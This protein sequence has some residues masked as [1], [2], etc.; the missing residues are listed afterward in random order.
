MYGV[1]ATMNGRVRASTTGN[2]AGHT[3]R[4]AAGCYTAVAG[5]TDTAGN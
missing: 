2:Q 3:A 1:P 4:M 5:I